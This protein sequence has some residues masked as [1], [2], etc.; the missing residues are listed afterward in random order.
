MIRV[1]LD[2]AVQADIVHGGPP[3][4]WYKKNDG[5]ATRPVVFDGFVTGLFFADDFREFL[6]GCFLVRKNFGVDDFDTV[7]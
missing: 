5:A 3:L 2:D 4:C 1:A 7:L 6:D